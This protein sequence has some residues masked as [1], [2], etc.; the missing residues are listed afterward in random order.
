[1]EERITP[2]ALTKQIN[3]LYW[4]ISRAVNELTDTMNYIDGELL[5]N[6]SKL[7]SALLP[8]TSTYPFSGEHFMYN[9]I[10]HIILGKEQGGI[11]AVTA[12][13]IKD[14]KRFDEFGKS[15]WEVSTLRSFLNKHFIKNYNIGDLL[16]FESDLTADNGDKD[17]GT[18]RDYIFLL[19]CD[20]IRKYKEYL[21]QSLPVPEDSFIC[22]AF[23]TLTPSNG[24]IASHCNTVR[25][26]KP[27]SDMFDYYVVDED[28]TDLYVLPACLFNPTVFE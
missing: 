1:M 28:D 11:L 16:T 22:S 14:K 10:D 27:S 17:F 9:G 20:L 24:Y 13:P 18:C 21:L 12:E 7:Q 23:F 4:N 15:N 25:A 8:E 2:E 26:Y 19:S 3:H 5:P 6:I